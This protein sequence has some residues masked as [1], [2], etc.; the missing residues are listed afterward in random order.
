MDATNTTTNQLLDIIGPVIPPESINYSSVFIAAATISLA[1]VVVLFKLHRSGFKYK[2]LILLLGKRLKSSNI[3]PKQA[4]YKLA[5]ILN[6]AHNTNRLS[7]IKVDTTETQ[8]QDWQKFITQ[9][10]NYR[11][12]LHE[13]GQPEM[14]ELIAH[15]KSWT[16]SSR[17]KHD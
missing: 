2:I 5:E 13:V 12:T 4:A 10:S 7:I 14:L 3:T 6:A 9:L 8:N 1:V 11:Y 16:V 17:R 15:A